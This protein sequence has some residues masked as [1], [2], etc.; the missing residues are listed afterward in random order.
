M[1]YC[2]KCGIENSDESIFCS[3]CGE[4]I[5]NSNKKLVFYSLAVNNLNLFQ[6][7]IILA[8][9]VLGVNNLFDIFCECFPSITKFSSSLIEKTIVLILSFGVFFI[10]YFVFKKI[11]VKKQFKQTDNEKTEIIWITVLLI[12]L[13]IAIVNSFSDINYYLLFGGIIA[14]TLR[15]LL[16]ILTLFLQAKSKK[17]YYGLGLLIYFFSQISNDA[18]VS[19][20]FFYFKN[21]NLFTNE[22][23][24]TTLIPVFLPIIFI[25]ISLIIKLIC[26]KKII[27][28]I[29]GLLW[30]SSI[31]YIVLISFRIKTLM[32]FY[33]EFLTISYLFL[34]SFS[35]VNVNKIIFFQE[36]MLKKSIIAFVSASIISLITTV[37]FAYLS[38]INVSKWLKKYEKFFY[39]DSNSVEEI[40]WTQMEND[41]KRTKLLKSSEIF[42]S[43]TEIYNFK[44][45][46]ANFYTIKNIHECY[47][48]YKKTYIGGYATDQDILEKYDQIY[49]DEE[50]ETSEVLKSSFKMFQE[51]KPTKENVN[52]YI[53]DRSDGYYVSVQNN[54]VFPIE[55]ININLKFSL[56][57]LKIGTYSDSE[58][59]HGEKEFQI[60]DIE[61]NVEK[62]EKIDIDYDD[63]YKGYGSY[64][65]CYVTGMDYNILEVY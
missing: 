32:L 51:M 1:K 61:P 30:I 11:N 31:V 18:W 9:S 53:F 45:I 10:L 55:N 37:S 57:F 6:K 8:L 42:L 13:L 63:Y 24:M 44:Q 3:N 54:N 62:T 36:K 20:R 34:L 59:S 46:S 12:N 47:D 52:V 27:D 33:F 5:N 49:I 16:L 50:W 35:R 40:D 41:K 4:K 39:E 60:D 15:I 7:T 28:Y 48:Y 64:F 23:L 14:N 19:M 58:F 21:R 29:I 22:N 56:Y 17:I 65:K 38:Y 2:G 26:D 25:F 43:P